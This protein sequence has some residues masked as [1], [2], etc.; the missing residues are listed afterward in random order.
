MTFDHIMPSSHAVPRSS[1][2]AR[3]ANVVVDPRASFRD[4]AS[5][6][7]WFVAFLGVILLRF[8]SVFVFYQPST[9]PAKLVGGLLFQIV[10]TV[11]LLVA[12]GLVLWSASRACG[13]RVGWPVAF[14]ITV[15]VYFA[16]TVATVAIASVA[17]AVLPASADVDLRSPPFTNLGALAPDDSVA[18]VLLA[19]LDVRWAYTLVLVALGLRAGVPDV[20]VSRVALAVASGYGVLLGLALVRVASR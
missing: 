20:R 19:H 11:P 15:H 13:V 18:R 4:V 16:Y 9:T 14:D 5:D 10:T 17:G 1:A 8:T 12:L 7:R 2:L 3:L 6:P